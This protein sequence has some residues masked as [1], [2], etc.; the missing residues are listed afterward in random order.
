VHVKNTGRICSEGLRAEVP[1]DRGQ[2]ENKL[3]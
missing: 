2:K 3:Q 1:K